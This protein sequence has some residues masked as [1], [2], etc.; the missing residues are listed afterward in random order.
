MPTPWPPLIPTTRHSELKVLGPG[1][2]GRLRP[3]RPRLI[4][5][6]SMKVIGRPSSRRRP[7]RGLVTHRAPH[8]QAPNA[9]AR[10]SALDSRCRSVLETLQLQSLCTVLERPVPPQLTRRGT[11]RRRPRPTDMREAVRSGT[12][13]GAVRP[14]VWPTLTPLKQLGTKQPQLLRREARDT[15]AN[16]TCDR[17]RV[18]L[19]TPHHHLS[20]APRHPT[21]VVT[22]Y[23]QKVPRGG[24]RRCRAPRLFLLGR[25]RRRPGGHSKPRRCSRT[26]I[27]P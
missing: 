11:S 2:L 17:P 1:L 26:G 10:A 19:A 23:H 5:R 12:L 7:A 14:S 8:I 21:P 27:D 13:R 20:R 9:R 16:T 6:L 18:S 3:R 4:R 22:D 25:C 24:P 15:L